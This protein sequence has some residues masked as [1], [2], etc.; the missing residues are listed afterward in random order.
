MHKM[1]PRRK[2]RRNVIIS[3]RTKT[4]KNQTLYVFMCF[5]LFRTHEHFMEFIKKIL[6]INKLEKEIG[7]N[8][9][10]IKELKIITKS[11]EAKNYEN[12][13]LRFLKTQKSTTEISK[14]L[15][16]S[17]S[18]TSQILNRLEKKNKIYEHSKKGRTIL[19][20]IRR[21]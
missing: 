5:E 6:G 8:K 1:R 7:Q 2:N 11:E 15:K 20:K 18:R 19:Y 3:T 10:E 9:K 12:Q 17:R 13:I 4:I 21:S 16:I 14:K